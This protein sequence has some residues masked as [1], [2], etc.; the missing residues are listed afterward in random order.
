VSHATIQ[1]IITI[2]HGRRD[3]SRPHIRD[4]IRRLEIINL[5]DENG[6]SD[7]QRERISEEL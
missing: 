1:E 6:L 5:G 4:A 7:S 2:L 3:V